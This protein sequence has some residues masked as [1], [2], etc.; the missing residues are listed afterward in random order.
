MPRGS[1]N[2]TAVTWALAPW[3]DKLTTGLRSYFGLGA[4]C[5]VAQ[6]AKSLNISAVL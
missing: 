2:E 4:I 5:A 6:I 1:G 3:F